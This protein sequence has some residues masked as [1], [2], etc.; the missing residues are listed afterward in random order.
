MTG[1]WWNPDWDIAEMTSEVMADHRH[2]ANNPREV[3]DDDV[4]YMFEQIAT[5]FPTGPRP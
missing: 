2:L 3:T 4:R 5:D 1:P